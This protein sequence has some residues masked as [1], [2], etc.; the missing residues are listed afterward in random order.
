MKFALPFLIVVAVLFSSNV[1]AQKRNN[2]KLFGS[3]NNTEQEPAP[4]DS[5]VEV[6]VDTVIEAIVP[7]GYMP[8]SDTS[9]SGVVEIFQDYRIRKLL[10]RQIRINDS[11]G[12]IKGYRVQ[13]WFG[14]GAGSAT[15]A[16][17]IESD[18][19][20][21]HPD[22]PTYRHYEKSAFRLKAGN[23]RTRMQAQKFHE[24]IRDAFPAA[25]II[26]DDID[27]PALPKH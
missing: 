11:T 9:E 7:D 12:T 17:E 24:S 13:I 18:F 27:L 14:S 6:P 26:A 21:Q 10:D 1:F 5:V 23:F 22:V 19:L 4:T 16:K 8:A 3:K 2:W 25:F 15:K 20:G